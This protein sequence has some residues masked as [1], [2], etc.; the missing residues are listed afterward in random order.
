MEFKL[1]S[2]DSQY[3]LQVNPQNKKELLLT[4]PGTKIK[5]TSQRPI[6]LDG[7][8]AK[9]VKFTNENGS[10]RAVVSLPYDADTVNYKAYIIN[11]ADSRRRNSS[12]LAVDIS[13][14]A[15]VL[16]RSLQ[17]VAGHV[18][19]I[20]PGHGGS[21]SGA[22]GPDGIMEKNV[23]L[24]VAKKVYNILVNNGAT[25]IMTRTV[26]KD[27]YAPNASAV[28]ELQARVNVGE[29]TKNT[30][31]FLS[32][33]ANSFTSPSANGTETYYYQ[34][35]SQ[36]EKLAS[37][38]Q[39]EMVKSSGLNDRGI[40]AA[41]FYVLK[42]TSMPSALVELAFIS[43]YREEGLLNADDFQEMMAEAICRAISRYF[44]AD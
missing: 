13:K 33:H 20:D 12:V 14:K 31:I 40:A 28:Q 43:N 1:G 30:D 2:K 4:F 35:S 25:V 21:D 24:A 19:V 26:D 5:N 9:S 15:A 27:V 44:Q 38:I 10:G 18:I 39:D 32:V 37:L 8:L 29:Y 6:T 17:A 7:S 3:I 16:S 41:N 34:S 36:G 11:N 42:H 22:V 23:T